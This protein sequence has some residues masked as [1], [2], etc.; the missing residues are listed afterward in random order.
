MRWQRLFNAIVL[1]V[2]RSPAHRVVSGS[3]VALT[4]TGRK[5]GRLYTIPANYVLDGSN[6][7]VLSPCERTWWRNL[8]REVPMTV[9]LRGRD[10][11]CTGR[12]FTDLEHVAAGLMAFLR[13]STRYQKAWMVPLDASGEPRRREDLARAAQRAALIRLVPAL[14]MAPTDAREEVRDGTLTRV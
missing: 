14:T 11:S 5:S 2:V 6:V 7:L 8:L 1:S 13:T 9:R 4:F 10:I 12:A 3:V